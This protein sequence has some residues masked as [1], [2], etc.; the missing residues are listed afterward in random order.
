MKSLTEEINLLYVALTRNVNFFIF[1]YIL[2]QPTR[3]IICISR[4]FLR[5]GVDEMFF[6]YHLYTA[7]LSILY[8]STVYLFFRIEI[9]TVDLE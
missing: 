8:R 3:R 7:R 4:H 2:T 1:V 5:D 6:F 9:W